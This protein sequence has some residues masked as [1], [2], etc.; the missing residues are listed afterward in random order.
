MAPRGGEGRADA[1]N[2]RHVKLIIKGLDCF[3][4]SVQ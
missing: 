1:A 4:N 3:D 2:I